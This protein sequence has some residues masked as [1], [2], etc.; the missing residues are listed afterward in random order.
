MQETN[1]AD[2]PLVSSDSSHP[3]RLQRDADI[4]LTASEALTILVLL[5]LVSEDTAQLA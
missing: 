2:F 5:M 4:L 3:W 1:I